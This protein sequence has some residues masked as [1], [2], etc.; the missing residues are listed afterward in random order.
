MSEPTRLAASPPQSCSRGES[1]GWR[2]RREPR[3]VGEDASEGHWVEV[4]GLRGKEGVV[5][6]AQG[7]RG[8][9]RPNPSLAPLPSPPPPGLF[10]RKLYQCGHARRR[11]LG[12]LVSRCRGEEA[13]FSCVAAGRGGTNGSPANRP[14]RPPPACGSPGRL[15]AAPQGACSAPKNGLVSALGS[16]SITSKKLPPPS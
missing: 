16:H 14:P 8:G 7:E 13:G 3:G 5:L 10:P 15:S 1:P 11:H 12:Q 2:V 4:L 9:A 6:F